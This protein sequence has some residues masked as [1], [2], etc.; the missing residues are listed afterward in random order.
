MNTKKCNKGKFIQEDLILVYQYQ[1]LAQLVQALDC[2]VQNEA[3]MQ[4]VFQVQFWIVV[5]CTYSNTC[6]TL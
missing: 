2:C 4:S 5:L 6:W 1:P 3:L